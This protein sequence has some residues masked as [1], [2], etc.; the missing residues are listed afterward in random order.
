[1]CSFCTWLTCMFVCHFVSRMIVTVL[2][3]TFYQHRSLLL[4][5][6]WGCIKHCIPFVQSVCQWHSVTHSPVLVLKDHYCW[7][8]MSAHFTNGDRYLRQTK[9]PKLEYLH[10]VH[11]RLIYCCRIPVKIIQSVILVL[12]VS[13]QYFD[14]VGWVFWRVKTVSHITYTVLSGM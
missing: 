10:S 12:Y 8:K 2:T 3:S 4:K 11:G 13:L 7:A 14:T 6:L 5:L 1:M 9:A